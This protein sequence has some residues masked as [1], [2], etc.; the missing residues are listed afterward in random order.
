MKVIETG[1]EGFLVKE[2]DVFSNDVNEVVIIVPYN[3]L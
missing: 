1:M 2:P 3:Y